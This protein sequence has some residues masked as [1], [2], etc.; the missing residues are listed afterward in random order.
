M[1]R[2]SEIDQKL[3]QEFGENNIPVTWEF[4]PEDLNFSLFGYFTSKDKNIGV[5]RFQGN[6]LFC[7]SVSMIQLIY[8][9]LQ[10]ITVLLRKFIV[11]KPYLWLGNMLY[12][13]ICH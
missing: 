8:S 13:L 11:R 6:V 10:G 12:A 2:K 1:H 5:N 7:L 4:T 9:G 3:G